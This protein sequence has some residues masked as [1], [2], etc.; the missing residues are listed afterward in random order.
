[1]RDRPSKRPA[2][3]AGLDDNEIV[4]LVARERAAHRLDDEE[5][6]P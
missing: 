6:T 4:E 5:F 1:M 2:R 3:A